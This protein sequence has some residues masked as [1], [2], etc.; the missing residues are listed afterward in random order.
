MSSDVAFEIE[1]VVETFA[2]KVTFVFFERR[3]VATMTVEHSNMLEGL[4]TQVAG[5]VCEVAL[6]RG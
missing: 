1:G 2:A 3:M 4:A 6:D 5:V